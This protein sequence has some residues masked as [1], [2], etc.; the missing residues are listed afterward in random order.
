[1]ARRSYRLCMNLVRR[2]HP[3]ATVFLGILIALCLPFGHAV[4]A[5]GEENAKF[6]GVDLV[7]SD[8]E[9]MPAEP[10]LPITAADRAFAD[11]VETDSLLPAAALLAVAAS[12]LL[13]ALFLRGKFWGTC[14]AVAAVA[15]LAIGFLSNMDDAYVG[16]HLAFWLP[17]A[18]LVVR[19]GL[20]VATGRGRAR[21]PEAAVSA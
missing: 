14:C 13:L 9:P 17:V 20:A 5:C 15:T 4:S 1:M 21:T 18:G 8:V 2:F 16:W 3:S 11:Q 12:G 7:R 19:V 6:T 10:G